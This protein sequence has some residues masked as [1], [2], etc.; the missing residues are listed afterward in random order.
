[1]SDNKEKVRDSEEHNKKVKDRTTVSR[2]KPEEKT[3]IDLSKGSFA[4][5]RE[6]LKL[7][8]NL[9]KT[10][11]ISA[12][13]EASGPGFNCQ[14]C[15]LTFKDNLGYLDHLNSP[16]HLSNA[17]LS[18]RVERSTLA[19]VLERLEQ[20]KIKPVQRDPREILEERLKVELEEKRRKKEMKKALKRSDLD[21]ETNPDEMLAMGFNGFGS[22]KK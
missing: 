18:N 21:L 6:S 14:M 9:N 8:S 2:H 16:I 5:A 22:S 11:I 12:A 1:M 20:R 10:R 17:G 19:Q 7:D 4:I 13:D 3:N 15:N